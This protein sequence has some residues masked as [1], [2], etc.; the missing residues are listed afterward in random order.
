[1]CLCIKPK[2]ISLCIGSCAKLAPRFCG[3]FKILKRIR[4]LAYRL[5][6]PP[7]VK[8]HD[9]FYVSLLKKYVNDVDHVIDWF[10][11]QM[12]PDGEF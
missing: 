9:V 2:K 6:L 7:R 10:V 5:A 4:P 1:V 3:P 11:M 8:V 12:E